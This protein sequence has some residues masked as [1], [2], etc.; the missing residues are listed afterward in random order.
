[1]CLAIQYNPFQSTIHFNPCATAI[2]LLFKER[3]WSLAT[4]ME[5]SRRDKSFKII[6]LINRALLINRFLL[7]YRALLSQ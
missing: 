5:V 6:L 7:I 4:M 2:V 1:M 3:S